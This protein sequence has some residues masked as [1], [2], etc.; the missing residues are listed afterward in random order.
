MT[1]NGN[2]EV[3]ISTPGRIYVRKR[4]ENPKHRETI[5]VLCDT[6]FWCA[7]YLG[8]FMLP[9]ENRCPNCLD[10]ELSSFPILS[11]ESFTFNYDQKRGVE[12]NFGSRKK[13]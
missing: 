7:T 5:F 1:K 9:P 12:L 4:K 8:K 2:L 10:T 6:C 3:P 11:D 13:K